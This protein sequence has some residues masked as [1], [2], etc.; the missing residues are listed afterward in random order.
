MLSFF[1]SVAFC[2]S[3]LGV[4]LATG[5]PIALL[6]MSVMGGAGGDRAR[7]GAGRIITIWLVGQCG[8]RQWTGGN[9]VDVYRFCRGDIGLFFVAAIIVFNRKRLP[10]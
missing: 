9:M 5:V 10:I 8:N 2:G 7:L 3:K 6:F 4:G 1:L